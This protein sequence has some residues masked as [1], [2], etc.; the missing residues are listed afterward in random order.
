VAE[1]PNWLKFCIR[2]FFDMENTNL[3]EFFI[4]TTGGAPMRGIS[5]KW[6]KLV[7]FPEAGPGKHLHASAMRAIDS[8]TRKTL[9]RSK[10]SSKI[11]LYSQIS[12]LKTSILEKVCILTRNTYSQKDRL[13]RIHHILLP[14][15]ETNFCRKRISVS[16][17]SRKMLGEI[18]SD[19]PNISSIFAG[20]AQ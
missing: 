17:F 11:D 7:I 15:T 14:N 20:Q 18:L 19:Q 16:K 6:L 1:I 12:T 4:L 5:L 3:K 8:P 9:I 2:G 13:D 10:V